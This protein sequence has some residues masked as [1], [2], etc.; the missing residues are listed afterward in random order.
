MPTEIVTDTYTRSQVVP[1]L[2][3]CFG[4]EFVNVGATIVNVNGKRLLPAPGAGLSGEI[5]T[6]T[7]PLREELTEQGFTVTFAAGAGSAVEISQAI[8]I[9]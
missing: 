4:Y 5:R 2:K 6:F 9:P 3:C 1:R 7:D 8:K